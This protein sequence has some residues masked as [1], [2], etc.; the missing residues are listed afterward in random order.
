MEDGRWEDTDFVVQISYTM[1]LCIQIRFIHSVTTQI[2]Y[3]SQNLPF[4]EQLVY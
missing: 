4:L 1:S 2:Q 3:V